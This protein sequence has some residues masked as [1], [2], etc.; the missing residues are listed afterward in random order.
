MLT[1][2][3]CCKKQRFHWRHVRPQNFQSAWNP[4]VPS[5]LLLYRRWVVSALV[6][7]FLSALRADYDGNYS[8]SARLVILG[9]QFLVAT[10]STPVTRK[11]F[12]MKSGNREIAL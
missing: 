11:E 4:N 2:F 7:V 12:M 3:R 1:L 10:T 8:Y 5:C 6:F 9:A